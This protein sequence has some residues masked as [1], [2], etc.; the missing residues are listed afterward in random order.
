MTTFGSNMWGDTWENVLFP[1]HFWNIF[2]R[3]ENEVPR[4]T[5]SVEGWHFRMNNFLSG[6]HPDMWRCLEMLKAEQ[7]HW[8]LKTTF[9]AGLR[10]I[11]LVLEV[12]FLVYAY[13]LQTIATT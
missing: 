13:L 12:H 9:A 10:L 2:G 8:E 3:F 1:C 7:L 6:A 5:N 11:I 4:T